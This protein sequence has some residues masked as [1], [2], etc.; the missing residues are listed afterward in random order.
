[1]R[2]PSHENTDSAALADE[3][4]DDIMDALSEVFE[5]IGYPLG[6]SDFAE[7]NKAI[8]KIVFQKV[9]ND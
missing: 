4:V 9:N 7:L 3:M 1:M 6:G 5:E 2:R 8:S